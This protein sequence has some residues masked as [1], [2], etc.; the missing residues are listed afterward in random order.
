MH[1]FLFLTFLLYFEFMVSP[2][3]KPLL[4][5]YEKSNTSAIPNRVKTKN[6]LILNYM[7]VF[8]VTCTI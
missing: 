8:K 6:I 3:L 2:L 5:L 7:Y 4:K 1:I